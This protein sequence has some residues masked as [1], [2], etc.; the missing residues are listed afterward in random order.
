MLNK[1]H[2]GAMVLVLT[3]L[4]LSLITVLTIMMLERTILASRIASI[5]I[6]QVKNHEIKK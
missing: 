1:K 4:I 3:L 5:E 6:D 2:Q